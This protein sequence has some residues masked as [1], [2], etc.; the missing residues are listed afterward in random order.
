MATIKIRFRPSSVKDKGGTLYYQII[1]KRQV[2]QLY[3]GFHL[4]NNEWDATNNSVIIDSRGNRSRTIYLSS[5]NDSIRIGQTK[6][7]SIVAGFDLSGHDYTV[8]DV[9]SRFVSPE[10]LSGVVGFTRKLVDELCRMGK[11][12]MARRYRVTLSNLLKFTGDREVSWGEINSTFVTGFEEFLR[13]R[14]LCRNSTSFYMRNLRSIINRAVERDHEVPRNPFRHVYMGI[15]KTVKR[16]VTLKTVCRIRDIDLRAY[17]HLDFA[18]N[19]FMFAFYTR[20]MSFIDIAFL[21]KS[22]VSNGVITYFRRKT[23]QQIQ[24][25]LESQTLEIM[26]KLGESNTAYLLPLIGNDVADADSQYRNMYHRVNRNLKKLG[27]MLQLETK[28]TLYVARHAW[29]SI[30][31]HNHVPISTISKAMGHDS[32]TTTLIY[33]S[34]IDSSAVDKANRKI[35]LLMNGGNEEELQY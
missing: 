14:G 10:V 7:K 35:M 18:R 6:L 15:D 3:T 17:P 13:K 16:A 2:K 32:E 1:H 20:G 21:K 34:S 31:H 4:N 22:D 9:V 26:K 28:L 5:V 25:R 33:L 27:E 12:S 29:A 11:K 8:E 19:V 24:V 30:A 23:S